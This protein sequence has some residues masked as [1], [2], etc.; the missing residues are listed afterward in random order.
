LISWP[1]EVVPMLRSACGLSPC[2]PPDHVLFTVMVPVLGVLVMVQTICEFKP[3]N[4]EPLEPTGTLAP[5]FALS[6]QEVL[7]LKLPEPITSDT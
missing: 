7:E 3:T 5:P 1:L 6:T 2:A 4:T